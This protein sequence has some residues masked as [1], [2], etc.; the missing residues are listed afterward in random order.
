[1]DTDR[2]ADAQ[3]RRG[4]SS[5]SG[6]NG[7]EMAEVLSLAL[8]FFGLI[9][10]GYGSGKI[11]RLPDV[12]LAWL[13]FFVVYLALPALFFQM[14]SQTP[15]E[16]LANWRFV[17]ATTTA[18]AAAFAIAFGIGMLATRG[19]IPEATIQGI[20]GGYANV[21]YMGPGL[22]L[23]ALGPTA[24]VP[25]AL[26]FCF[27]S[28]LLFTL[29]PVLMAIG[30]TEGGGVWATVKVC[31]KRIFTHPF[32]LATIAGVAAAA[33]EFRPP[34]ALDQLLT[35]LRSAAAPCALFAMGVTA[36]LR[37]VPGV[38]W[39]LPFLLI[40]KLVLHP[41]MVFALMLLIGGFSSSW[42]ETAV[43]M[44]SLPPAANAFVLASQ[45]RVYVERASGAVLFGTAAS[46]L[47]V[48]LTLYLITEDLLPLLH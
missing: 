9:F 2:G 20:V 23:A 22:T 34:Q 8:P 25:A 42:V 31:L 6:E 12:G 27:D 16:E 35:Y 11:V 19:R 48:T 10:L 3:S 32:I 21:G 33:L 37:P 15:I 28:M 29:V 39:E 18:T 40:V 14:L 38:P 5:P 7:R 41:L 13:Q 45:Y 17:A 47:T 36:A 1:M 43:L 46:V 26:I 4:R 44:A 30:G 24:T